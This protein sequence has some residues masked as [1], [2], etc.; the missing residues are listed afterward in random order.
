[1]STNMYLLVRMVMLSV[2][3]IAAIVFLMAVK[4]Y[5]FSWT[6]ITLRPL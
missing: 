4:H 2:K 6:V 3:A 1:M 5:G